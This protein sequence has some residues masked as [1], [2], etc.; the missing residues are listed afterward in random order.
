MISLQQ[1]VILL[2][3]AVVAVPIF[4]RIGMGAVLGYLAA[5][6]AIGPSGIGVFVNPQRMLHVSEF[7]VVMLMFVIGL[8][9]HPARLKALRKPIFGTGSLQVALCALALGLVAWSIQHDLMQAFV[10]GT[11]L[12]LSSTAFVLQLLAEKKQ[13]TTSQGRIAF[14]TLLFQDLAV[15]PL[16][17]VIPPL[18]G[19]NG[20]FHLST[21]ALGI[22]RVCVSLVLVILVGRYLVRPLMRFVQSVHVR[23]IS[24][25]QA[26]LLVTGAAYLM[27]WLGL[28]MATGAFLAGVTLAQSE[29]RHQLEGDIE[30]FKGLLLGLFFMAVGMTFNFSLVLHEPLRILGLAA[31]LILIKAVLVTVVGRVSAELTW[32]KSMR[33]GLLLSQGGEFAFVVFALAGRLSILPPERES[34]LVAVVTISMALT[35]LLYGFYE[36]CLAPR[37]ERSDKAYDSIDER[38]G[39]VIAGFGRF[40]QITGRLLNSLRIPF[41]AL[42]INM[43]QVLVVRRFG[44]E[45]HFGDA[46]QLNVLA[47]AGLEEAKL[48]VLAMDDVQSSLATVDLVKQ[49]FPKVRILARARNRNHYHRLREAGADWIIRETFHSA[50]EMATTVLIELGRSGDEARHLVQLFRRNDEKSLH[51][52][53]GI[54]RDREQV[55]QSSQ[56]A[57]DELRRLFEEDNATRD[58]RDKS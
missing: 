42:D 10:I 22:A 7:G 3:A 33:L 5:G 53:H 38:N 40:G 9:L 19:H 56:D 39:V 14:T 35:P 48:L 34:L 46:S 26:L 6:A 20:A 32:Q 8:E 30:P 27:Q 44:N 45:V 24:I 29:F 51:R 1:T 4:K 25:A 37:L 31:G 15:I 55:I 54:H 43:E 52:Q 18:A 13:L 28:S 21:A 41:T 16:L 11:A 2:L 23:E 49:N 58:K 36:R 50:L 12:A 17:A 47:S 57:A